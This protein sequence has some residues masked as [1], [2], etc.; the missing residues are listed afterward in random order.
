MTWPNGHQILHVPVGT[1]S[2][3][4]PNTFPNYKSV[5]VDAGGTLEINTEAWTASAWM[6][7]GCAGD[8]ILRGTLLVRGSPICTDNGYTFQGSDGTT[9]TAAFHQPSGGS[10]GASIGSQFKPGGTPGSSA[11]GN[12]GGGA[13][14]FGRGG[15]GQPSRAGDGGRANG[16]DGTRWN[17][18]NGGGGG[19][20]ASSGNDAAGPGGT[21]VMRREETEPLAA[22]Q[23]EAHAD[24]TAAF[25]TS[26][27]SA[28]SMQP[29]G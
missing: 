2:I 22:A 17:I 15:D 18:G 14:A 23:A 6:Q 29:V 24:F 7:I 10:G 21:G 9:R 3:V 4:A 20:V 25:S 27:S 11:Y 28:L 1:R 19:Q 12:G 16:F 13:A 8:F 26:V 5:I